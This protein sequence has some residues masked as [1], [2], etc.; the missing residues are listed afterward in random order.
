MQSNDPDPIPAETY[1]VVVIG[2]GIAGLTAGLTA[3]RLGRATM[4]VTGAVLGGHLISVENVEG[5][6]GFADGIAGFELCPLAQAQAAE[7]GARVSM[8]EVERL[9]RSDGPWRVITSDAAYLTPAVIVATGTSMRRLEVP[10]EEDFFGK[11]VSQCASCDAPLLRG[12]VAVV[13]GGGD[14]AAQEALTL[15]PHV[16]KVVLLV[17]DRALSAQATYRERLQSEAAIEIRYNAVVEAILGDAGVSAVRY[18]NRADGTVEEVEAAGVFIFVGLRPNTGFL[19]GL[20]TL[21]E[22][23]HIPTDRHMRAALPGLFAAGTVRATST[24]QAVSAA[25]EGAGAAV[26]VDRYIEDGAWHA[27]GP[28]LE[29]DLAPASGASND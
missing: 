29:T 12:Q 1:D 17:R 10:G 8:A 14:S 3:A 22:T 21:V 18:R 5:F 13:V 26:A 24:G 15:V 9:E 7:A 23:G 28:D 27:L 16:A 11:G 19:D 4:I 25:G 6:P 2:S 20:L